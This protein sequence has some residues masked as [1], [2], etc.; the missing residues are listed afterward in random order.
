M[1]ARETRAHFDA[2]AREKRPAR[3]LGCGFGQRYD[4]PGMSRQTGLFRQLDAVLENSLDAWG[5]LPPG[6]VLD[7]G[8][9]TFFYHSLLAKRFPV[10]LGVDGSFFM[11][12]AGA[13]KSG[14]PAGTLAACADARSLPLPDAAFSCVFS[15][16]VLHHLDE[17]GR[18]IREIRRVL[19]PGGLY[20][21]IEPNL[22]NPGM[23]LA[24]LLPPE[25][26]DALRW[27]WPGRLRALLSPIFGEVRLSYF[28]LSLSRGVSTVANALFPFRA[29]G[30]GPWA[31][32]M[33]AACRKS[34]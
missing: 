9:G 27:N 2:L 6:P 17:P 32:R 1:N 12:S 24:H 34:P 13:G 11:L 30:S 25:E 19:A 20:V 33:V 15:L 7:L 29:N 3:G 14:F 8:C 28:N 23:L 22:L 21:A 18:V 16:D 5:A 26:R 10:V 4:P 31:M